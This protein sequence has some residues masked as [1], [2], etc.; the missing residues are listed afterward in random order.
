MQQYDGPF[1]QSA[2]AAVNR[3]R[4]QQNGRRTKDTGPWEVGGLFAGPAFGH[5]SS[6]EQWSKINTILLEEIKLNK[7]SKEYYY[8]PRT[9]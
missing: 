3:V 9:V 6:A 8:T 1:G 2:R 7:T 4:P 5:S